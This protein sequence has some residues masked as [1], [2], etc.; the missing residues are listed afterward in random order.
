[1]F[2]LIINAADMNRRGFLKQIKHFNTFC[3]RMTGAFCAE[4]LNNEKLIF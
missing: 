1:M 4:A 2:A 3:A